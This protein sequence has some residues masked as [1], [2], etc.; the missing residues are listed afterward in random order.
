MTR[1]PAPSW[2]AVRRVFLARPPGTDEERG[3]QV[4]EERITLWQARSLDHAIE[5]AE[6]EAREYADD[7]GHL[8]LSQAYALPGPPGHG[9]EVF[10][11][12]RTSPLP[13]GAYLDAHFHTGHERQ[14]ETHGKEPS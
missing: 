4:Y 10:S 13:P 3:G 2:Y 1:P 5:L 6:Q 7:G 12:M 9:A 8:G 11:L 14:S